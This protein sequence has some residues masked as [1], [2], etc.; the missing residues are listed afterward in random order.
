MKNTAMITVLENHD[1][2]GKKE[3][4]VHK[5]TVTCVGRKEDFSDQKTEKV[6]AN[7][8]EN[9]GKTCTKKS[10]ENDIWHNILTNDVSRIVMPDFCARARPHLWMMLFNKLKK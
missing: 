2:Q 9:I 5:E 4:P 8:S 6:E 7:N 3:N 1:E 10:T